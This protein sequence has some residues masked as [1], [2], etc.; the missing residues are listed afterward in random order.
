MMLILEGKMNLYK[1]GYHLAV[2]R[3]KHFVRMNRELKNEVAR[4]NHVLQLHE[5]L[6]FSI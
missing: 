1:R 5:D 2:R 4:L 3:L 6:M